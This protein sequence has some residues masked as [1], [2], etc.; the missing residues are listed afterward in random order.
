MSGVV[1][2]FCLLGNLRVYVYRLLT[3]GCSERPWLELVSFCLWFCPLLF[4][5]S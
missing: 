1:Q 2:T 3:E 5:V 4:L